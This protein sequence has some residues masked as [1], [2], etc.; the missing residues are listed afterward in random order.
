MHFLL[1]NQDKV[2]PTGGT[3][4]IGSGA[5]S[6]PL[7]FALQGQ[8]EPTVIGK[9]NKPMMDAIIA[10]HHFDPKRALMVGD[11]LLTDIA[12]SQNCEMRSLLV[13]GGVTKREQVYGD[14]PSEIVP[15]FVMESL[16][17]FAKILAN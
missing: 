6:S 11:N 10:E 4:Y 13:M 9:P 12:F 8:R 16:G 1:T 5:I 2:F 15:T 17:D 7:V 14:N 3:T